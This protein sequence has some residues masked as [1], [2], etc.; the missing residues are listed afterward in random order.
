VTAYLR[1]LEDR[2]G[3]PVSPSELVDLAKTDAAK[4]AHENALEELQTLRPGC[5]GNCLAIDTAE[6]TIAR[7]FLERAGQLLTGHRSLWLMV[8]DSE[9][10]GAVVVRVRELVERRVRVDR[11][12]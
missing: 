9:Y 8:S 5:D 7:E 1:R 12:G 11:R 3:H 2:L 6:R 10:C 4:S